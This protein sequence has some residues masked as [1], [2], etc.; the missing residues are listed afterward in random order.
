MLTNQASRRH[1][2]LPHPVLT[3]I[4][5]VFF[6]HFAGAGIVLAQSP[7]DAGVDDPYFPN[8]GNGGYDVLHYAIDARFDV[9]ANTLQATTVIDAQAT[10][11]LNRLN[12][13]FQRIAIE[14]VLVDDAE[15]SF[16]HRNGELVIT[17][18]AAITEGQA[19]RVEVRYGGSPSS[20]PF[21]Q[22]IADLGWYDLES[23]LVGMGEPAGSSTWYPVNEHPSDKATYTFRLTAPKPYMA[24][25]S[26]VLVER[27]AGL[28]ETTFV[29]E[30]RQPMASYLT[31][32]AVGDFVEISDETADGL[33]IRSYAPPNLVRRAESAFARTS[34]IIAAYEA[35]FGDYPFETVGG[36]VVDGGFGFA[37][38][39]QSMPI[40]DGMIIRAPVE[41]SER[42]IAHELAHQ[43]FG[44]SVSPAS[45]RDIWLNEGFATYAS[46]L[47]VE[48]SA[49]LSVFGS[50]ARGSYVEL[51]NSRRLTRPG[52]A[53]G[54]VT[55]D[56]GV[57]AIFDGEVIYTRGAV[58]LHAL[59]LKVGD[60]AF[61]EIV[62]TYYDRF[63][64]GN[65]STEDFIAVAEE[66]SGTDLN[67]FFQ[68]WLF[69]AD[70][71][72]IPELES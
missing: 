11:G 16:E 14:S 21:Q 27:I 31:L 58:T 35:L 6:A 51:R 55:G 15:A 57:E 53:K 2:R 19:F 5:L 22:T 10:Q 64:F 41:F 47:W 24:V 72:L 70:V 23:H 42:F 50:L 40:Y 39:T 17:P 48:Q 29:W 68:G 32:V 1:F 3:L 44:N 56:P 66:V 45:W 60:D 20:Y 34:E 26:G 7:G 37:L 67:Y 63:K 62:R 71:P 38:E 18:A 12:L 59:R 28:D 52:D 33:P 46:W 25:A 69:E 54:P 61:F 4:G 30:M 8:L 65:A 43:W 49:G 13:D 36:L 9:E